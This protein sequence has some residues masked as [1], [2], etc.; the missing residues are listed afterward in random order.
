MLS[1]IAS[2]YGKLISVRNRLYDTGVLA[3]FYL[4][5]RTI[6]IGNIT[7]GGTGK[8]P[9]VAYVAGL[10][11]DRGETVCILTRG[12]GRKDAKRR[13]LVSDGETVL[14]DAATGGDE[15]VELARKLV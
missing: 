1:L 13:V 10:L 4:G 8:T 15:P 5:A 3:T 9:L 7:T 6:S 11:A 12:Y 14:V 2:I